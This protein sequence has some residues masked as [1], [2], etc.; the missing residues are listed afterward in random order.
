MAAEAPSSAQPCC[1]PCPQ[2]G[3]EPFDTVLEPDTLR[4]ISLIAE[5]LTTKVAND[6]IHINDIVRQAVMS[7]E[8]EVEADLSPEERRKLYVRQRE[9]RICKALD[10]VLSGQDLHHLGIRKTMLVDIGP[11]LAAG[12]FFFRVSLSVRRVWYGWGR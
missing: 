5:A 11:L 2:P 4:L 10:Q 7:G 1:P 9:D 12:E 6:L 8:E 3:A